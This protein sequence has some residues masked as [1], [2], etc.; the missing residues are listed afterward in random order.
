MERALGSHTITHA[1]NIIGFN[2]S[3]IGCACDN[4]GEVADVYG[5]DYMPSLE[6]ATD[7]I[8]K[9]R[10][11]QGLTAQFWG[12][13]TN[14]NEFSTHGDVVVRVVEDTYRIGN[15]LAPGPDGLFHR[16]TNDENMFML[17]NGCPRVR[18]A[19]PVADN[20]EIICAF[21]Q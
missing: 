13:I 9:I 7:A 17:L 14:N 1:T 20:A 11:S 8:T 19:A 3:Q 15:C 6:R 10:V 21:I 18:V 5:S 4:V 2:S 12:V 16:A